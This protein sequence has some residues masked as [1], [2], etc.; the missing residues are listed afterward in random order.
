MLPLIC[1]NAL[2]GHTVNGSLLFGRS[3]FI[4]GIEF[5]AK[6]QSCGQHQTATFIITTLALRTGSDKQNEAIYGDLKTSLQEIFPVV[7]RELGGLL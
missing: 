2:E 3:F 4:V 5:V 1:E 7:G 6:Y